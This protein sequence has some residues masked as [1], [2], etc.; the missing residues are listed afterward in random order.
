MRKAN[1]AF[2]CEKG[3][4]E[5]LEDYRKVFL[6]S[7]NRSKHGPISTSEIKRKKRLHGFVREE[8]K[9]ISSDGRAARCV[10]EEEEVAVT[11]TVGAIYLDFSKVFDAA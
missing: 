3:T 8:A 2:I 9:L 4:A 10:Q 11:V 7:W 5:G 6:T 1:R